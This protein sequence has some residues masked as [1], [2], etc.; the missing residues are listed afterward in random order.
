MRRR[1]TKTELGEINRTCSAFEEV[2]QPILPLPKCQ[3]NSSS[4]GGQ[5]IQIP[6]TI[7]IPVDIA[8]SVSTELGEIAYDIVASVTREDETIATTRHPIHLSR[9]VITDEPTIEYARSYPNSKMVTQITLSQHLKTSFPNLSF[10]MNIKLRNPTTPGERASELKC[11]A[12]RGIRCRVEE[13][14]KIYN[15]CDRYNTEENEAEAE[16]V[17]VREI[18]NGR[19]KTNWSIIED[20]AGA[21]LDDAQR[22]G[23]VD[24]VFGFSIPKS[25][26]PAKRTDLSCY[27]FNPERLDPVSLPRELRE[28]YVSTSRERLVMTVEHRLKLDLLTGEDTFQRGTMILVDRKPIRVALNASFPLLISECNG[29]DTEPVTLERRPPR[30]EEVPTAPPNY[31][32]HAGS[33]DRSSC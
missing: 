19:Q 9:Q 16:R 27:A 33:S 18:C 15:K 28:Y 22:S 25:V 4:R 2:T 10:A 21:Q 17:S 11:F 13:V 7:P 3:L 1:V 12:I 23:S 31:D 32:T 30:Y 5:I 14:T 24:V 20:P 29:K 26:N 6:F 8:G